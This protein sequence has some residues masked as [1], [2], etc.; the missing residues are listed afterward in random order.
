MQEGVQF[1]AATNLKS[2]NK[3]GMVQPLNLHR[4]LHRYPI[5]AMMLETSQ[6]IITR[7]DCPHL[8]T[9]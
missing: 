7:R 4:C 9:N 5:T 2:R 8:D 1:A 6:T 3:R